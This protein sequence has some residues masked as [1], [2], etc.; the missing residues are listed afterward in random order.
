[1][2]ITTTDTDEGYRYYSFRPWMVY[3]DHKDF[4]QLIN[5]HQIIG[6][7]KPSPFLLEQYKKAVSMEQE[8][9]EKREDEVS[10]KFNDLM[11]QLKSMDCKDSA[12]EDNIVSLFQ[13]DT[14]KM[15]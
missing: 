13:T 5:Y 7:A 3:Q 12:D 8:S 9:A 2:K 4:L 11:D 1:M 10:E 6:E 14:S 15:H